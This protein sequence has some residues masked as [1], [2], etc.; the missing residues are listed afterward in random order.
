MSGTSYTPGIV[1]GDLVTNFLLNGCKKKVSQCR[2]VPQSILRYS[3][4]EILVQKVS[5]LEGAKIVRSCRDPS[6]YGED[7]L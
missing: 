2:M 1:K 3:E 5:D 7:S 6:K 4:I